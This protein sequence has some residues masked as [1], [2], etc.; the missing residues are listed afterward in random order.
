V[1]PSDVEVVDST[2]IKLFIWLCVKEKV[3]TWEVLR[4]RGWQGP[5]ICPLCNRASEDIHHLLIHCDFTKDVWNRLLQ[6]FSLTFSWIGATISDCFSSWFTEKSAPHSLAA[7]VCWQIWIE[8]NKVI[9]DDVLPP[10][11]RYFTEFWLPSN[12]NRPL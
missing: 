12:G 1:A 6:H 11:L 5:G 2:K 9:F 3:L 8:R 10:L 4:K 7:H